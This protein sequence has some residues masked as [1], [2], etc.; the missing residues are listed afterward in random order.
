MSLT[1]AMLVN[2]VPHLMVPTYNSL[3]TLS[4]PPILQNHR[5]RMVLL[6]ALGLLPKLPPPLNGLTSKTDATSMR[7]W[8]IFPTPP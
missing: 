3:D 8:P 1:S 5:L 7:P 2:N 4:I 6:L